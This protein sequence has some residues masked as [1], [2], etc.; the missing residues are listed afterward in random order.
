MHAP[1]PAYSSAAWDEPAQRSS[2]YGG[3]RTYGAFSSSHIPYGYDA[4][5][6][7][8]YDNTAPD[9]NG[10]FDDTTMTDAYNS[11]PAQYRVQT[12]E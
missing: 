5:F 4:R 7:T 1:R 10:A 12:T 3:Y 2:D 9:S 11:D 8:G 6:N